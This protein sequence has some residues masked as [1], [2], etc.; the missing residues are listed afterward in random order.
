MLLYILYIKRYNHG[1]MYTLNLITL[2][3]FKEGS[4]IRHT[5]TETKNRKMEKCKYK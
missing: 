3:I 2:D 5:D 1:A 4:K